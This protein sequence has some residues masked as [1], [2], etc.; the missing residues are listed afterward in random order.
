MMFPSRPTYNP[1]QLDFL[2]ALQSM[3]GAKQVASMQTA[4]IQNHTERERCPRVFLHCGLIFAHAIPQ[5]HQLFDDRGQL[6]SREQFAY[7]REPTKF[8]RRFLGVWEKNLCGPALT[9]IRQAIAFRGQ[10]NT[11]FALHGTLREMQVCRLPDALLRNGINVATWNMADTAVEGDERFH[12]LQ[13]QRILGRAGTSIPQEGWNQHD[14]KLIGATIYFYFSLWVSKQRDDG[15]DYDDKYFTRCIF[16]EILYLSCSIPYNEQLTNLWATHPLGCTVR[17]VKDL[18]K[19]FDCVKKF[20]TLRSAGQLGCGIRHFQCVMANQPTPRSFLVVNTNMSDPNA[21][22]GAQFGHQEPF[23]SQMKQLGIEIRKRWYKPYFDEEMVAWGRPVISPW[24]PSNLAPP[25]SGLSPAQLFPPSRDE[26]GNKR[27]AMN[28]VPTIVITNP[29]FE[30]L[31]DKERN[32]DT[33]YQYLRN[34]CAIRE[35]PK[36]LCSLMIFCSE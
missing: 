15:G 23:A 29:P 12:P 28:E 18:C 5:D 34:R 21:S 32:G 14:A 31:H 9:D 25:V 20:V 4:S 10:F 8:G 7:V 16:G 13:F 17:W 2:S 22:V 19:V 11:L 26:R 24:V 36:I 3:Q 1:H 35:F 6:V 30:L 33:P 27:K